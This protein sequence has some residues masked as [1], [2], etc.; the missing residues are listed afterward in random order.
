MDTKDRKYS[1]CIIKE[2]YLTLSFKYYWLKNFEF[3]KLVH[4]NRW[5]N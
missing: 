4:F 2:K 3:R 5:F 1:K